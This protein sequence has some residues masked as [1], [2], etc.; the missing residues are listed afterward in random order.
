MAVKKRRTKAQ[1]AA[2]KKLVAFNKK[3]RSKK[4]VKKKKAKKKTK[5]KKKISRVSQATKKKPSA[6]L[7]KR[8]AKKKV[9]GYFPN[10]KRSE[11]YVVA[12][13]KSAKKYFTGEGFTSKK[14]NAAW[15]VQLAPAKKVA[16]KLADRTGKQY[17]I[18][19]AG[20]K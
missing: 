9:K 11:Y 5:Y 7:K 15:Y 16:Q 1:I 18:E 3:K 2:T 13:G 12:E 20:K 10:P 6:R 14:V 4:S 19:T 17:R 8:R